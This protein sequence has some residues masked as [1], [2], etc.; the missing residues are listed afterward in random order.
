MI[1]AAL[2]AFQQP[3]LAHR[4][5]YVM[6]NLQVAANADQ[7]CELMGRARKAGYNGV[8]LSD[9]KFQRLGEVPDFY[10]TNAKKVVAA[11]KASDMEIIPCVWPV[12]Y[13]SAM[14]AHDVNLIEGL[15]VRDAVFMVQ[16]GEARPEAGDANLLPNGNLEAAAGD[17]VANLAFQDGAGAS[18]FIDQGEKHEGRQSI[19][20][21]NFSKGNEAG[22]ARLC[23][24]LKVQ[25]FHQYVFSGWTKREGVRGLVQAIALDSKGKDL[26]VN[27]LAGG[28]TAPWTQFKYSFNSLSSSEV[29]IYAG[30]W[31]GSQGR[32]WWDDLAV[33]DAG[34]LNV[35]RRPGCPVKVTTGDGATLVEG[36]DFEE[37]RDPGLGQ[38]PWPGEYDVDHAAPFLKVLSGGRVK[39]G[40][41][42][43]V[44]YYHAKTGIGN[45]AAICLSEPKTS[46][47]MEDEARRVI[48]LFQP[49]GLFWSHDEIRIGGW[50][51]ACRRRTPGAILAENARVANRI[52]QKLLPG[53]Q[54]YV[55]SDMFDPA[56]NAVDGYYLTNGTL[57]ISWEGLPKNAIIV[58]WN[59]G[60]SS[61]SLAFF[62]ERGHSQILAGYYDAPVDGI[63][64]WLT[65][66]KNEKLDGVMYTTWVGDYS[67]LEAFAKAAWGS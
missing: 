33:R 26:I 4:W 23:W 30:V 8:V 44:S 40:D 14:L 66:A 41:R 51:E 47:I 60:Q 59:S 16:N 18:T 9:T 46:A 42:L 38:T 39:D 50:C 2:L 10:F 65:A 49:K 34:L 3:V 31:G 12:G 17:K 43:L 19:R 29:K 58:N 53:S 37:V 11:A 5:V 35:I 62:A 32:M 61:K 64:P 7:V 22:N 13:A 57:A 56:H 15:P 63:K 45:Q 20:L 67:N 24:N 36:K 21:E 48:E 1:F 55:W 6:T 25:P 52:Q 54:A 28:E 27:D